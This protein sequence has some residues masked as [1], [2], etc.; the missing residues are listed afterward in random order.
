[1]TRLIFK[2]T[3]KVLISLFTQSARGPGR[4]SFDGERALSVLS[5]G[6]WL[7]VVCGFCGGRGGWRCRWGWCGAGVWDGWMDGRVR[8]ALDV[9]ACAS[10]VWSRGVL[11]TCA[12]GM[13]RLDVWRP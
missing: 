1:M 2:L 6:G 5:G 9:M 4:E 11:L 10:D 7:V 13:G 3:E 8:S 12:V